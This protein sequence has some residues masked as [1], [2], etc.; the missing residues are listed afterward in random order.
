MVEGLD[1]GHDE[2]LPELAGLGGLPHAAGQPACLAL[3]ALALPFPSLSLRGAVG[4][5]APSSHG[6]EAQRG[7]SGPGRVPVPIPLPL[8]PPGIGRRRGRAGSGWADGS[9]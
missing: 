1:G 8:P 6:G 2:R 4:A 3:P 7:A 5:R 9:E